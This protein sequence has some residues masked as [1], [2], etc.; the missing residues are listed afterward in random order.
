MNETGVGEGLEGIENWQNEADDFLARKP[1]WGRG[2]GFN[3]G[4]K[5]ERL[6]TGIGRVGGG[7]AIRQ[8]HDVVEG[9]SVAVDV[10][11][12]NKMRRAETTGCG[13][14]EC[15]RVVFFLK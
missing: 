14:V 3:E 6:P 15:Q 12:G 9:V 2:T 10:L 4:C 11:D 1:G 13:A 5:T 8:R 7:D